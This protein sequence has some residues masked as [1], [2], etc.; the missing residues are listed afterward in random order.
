[1]R[2]HAT[3]VVWH[4]HMFQIAN[5][6]LGRVEYPSGLRQQWNIYGRD[7]WQLTASTGAVL[8]GGLFFSSSMNALRYDRNACNGTCDVGRSLRVKSWRHN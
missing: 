6:D 1:M 4:T 7:T 8:R 2:F 5:K 3:E